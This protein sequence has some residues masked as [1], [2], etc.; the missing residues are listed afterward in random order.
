M[1]R[2]ALPVLIIIALGI[3]GGTATS[4]GDP[5]EIAALAG[6][7][8]PACKREFLAAILVP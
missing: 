3:V 5:I 4:L 8:S 6:R 7:K 2:P 1:A